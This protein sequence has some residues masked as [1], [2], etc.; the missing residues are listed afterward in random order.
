M[1][2]RKM[3]MILCNGPGCIGTRPNH[4]MGMR[5]EAVAA[6]W[7][8]DSPRGIDYC[9]KPECQAAAPKWKPRGTCAFCSK[10]FSLTGARMPTQHLYGTHT[11][12]KVRCPGSYLV[13]KP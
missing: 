4:F 3:F 12:V 1:S 7:L 13:A 9:P 11:G 2:M 10:R 5:P 8:C 6:G